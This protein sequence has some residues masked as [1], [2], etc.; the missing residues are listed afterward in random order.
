MAFTVEAETA[1]LVAVSVGASVGI[2]VGAKDMVGEAVVGA[3]VGCV[4]AM[5]VGLNEIVGATVGVA[6]E[7]GG[8]RKKEGEMETV[9]WEFAHPPHT[10]TVVAPELGIINEPLVFANLFEEQLAPEK[11][12]PEVSKLYSPEVEDNETVR[13]SPKT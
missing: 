6:V 7:G 4:G 11:V 9:L 8:D 2:S 1:L 5:V 10:V 3:K 13:V 12:A